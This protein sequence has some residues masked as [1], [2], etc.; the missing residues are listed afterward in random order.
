MGAEYEDSVGRSFLNSVILN[1]KL[2]TGINAQS[3]W[4]CISAVLFYVGGV[5]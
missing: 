4:Q 1:S 3:C 5:H 2:N